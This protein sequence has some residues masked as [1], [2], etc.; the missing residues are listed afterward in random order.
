[1]S[2]AIHLEETLKKAEGIFLQLKNAKHLP[3]GV[4]EILGFPTSSPAGSARSSGT[5]TPVIPDIRAS[6][7]PSMQSQNAPVTQQL[8]SVSYTKGTSARLHLTDSMSRSSD[9]GMRSSSNG[10][11]SE[12]NTPD[13]S[14]IE[15][16]SDNY[17]SFS[18]FWISYTFSILRIVSDYITKQSKLL[19]Y[20]LQSRNLKLYRS[21][22]MLWQDFLL[23]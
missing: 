9:N 5:S 3:D 2:M 15:I 7:V 13:D 10:F 20:F 22:D 12:T 4:K 17:S 1:M 14:S 8:T 19:K 6:P 23:C 21:T 11:A 16:L 18:N